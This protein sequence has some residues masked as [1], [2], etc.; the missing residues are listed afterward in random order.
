MPVGWTD[1]TF[2]PGQR[3][4][5][6]IASSWSW[7][8]V[9][10]FHPVLFSTLGDMFFRYERGHEIYWLN[11]GTGSVAPIAGSEEAFESLLASEAAEELFLPDLISDLHEAGK[12]LQADEC[13]SYAIFPVFAEGKYEASNLNP[14]PSWEHFGLSG[15]LHKQLRDFPD[16]T[17]VSIKLDE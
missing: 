1:L 3:A 10:P 6:A 9:E 14:V 7:L 16:G 5:S 11:T 15:D 13:Y 8:L 2:D 4:L 17:K 12:L